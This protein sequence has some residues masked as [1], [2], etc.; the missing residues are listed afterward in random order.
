MSLIEIVFAMATLAAA[1]MLVFT[2][3]GFV[4]AR[5]RREQQRLAC[6]E[7]A[8][9]LMLMRLDDEATLPDQHLAIAYSNDLYRWSLSETP[10]PMQ[11]SDAVKEARGQSTRTGGARRDRIR[12]ITVTV[13]LGEDSGGSRDGSGDV[14][15]FA[16]GRLLDPLAF[17]RNPDSMDNAVYNRQGTIVKEL[18]GGEGR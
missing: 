1:A 4:H 11:E 12:Q 5:Q 18:L 14:P 7:I 10:V 6:A 9:R 15:R 2:A 16:L 3:I 17:D 13:W 8:N